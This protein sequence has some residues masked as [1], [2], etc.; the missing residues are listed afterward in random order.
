MARRQ[1]DQYLTVPWATQALVE[2]FPEI[3]GTR[4]LDPCCGDGRMAMALAS[5][6]DIVELNDVDRFNRAAQYLYDASRPDLYEAHDCDWVVTNPPFSQ[7]GEI[8]HQCLQ[9]A[10]V[11][12]ALLLRCTFGE[13][14]KGRQ[15]LIEWPPTALLMLPRIS[16][17]GDGSTDSAPCWWF[18][19]SRSVRPRI[20]VR[21]RAAAAGQQALLFTGGQG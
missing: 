19:W 14:C 15:W 17:T 6:F 3:K 8:A 10:R 18:V 20:V 13:P 21:S 9:H 5:R 16:F 1:L 4:L 11:G 2:E 12:V 7:A